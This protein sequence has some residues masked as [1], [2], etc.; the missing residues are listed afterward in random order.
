M[1]SEEMNEHTVSLVVLIAI[2]WWVQSRNAQGA[3]PKVV[4]LM[5]LMFKTL[6]AM[7]LETRKLPFAAR[8]G[9]NKKKPKDKPDAF[10]FGLW[11][12]DP[13]YVTI[14]SILALAGDLIYVLEKLM[15][16][17]KLL[18]L[19]QFMT[20]LYNQAKKFRDARDF[21]THM[22]EALR[23][24]SKHGISGPTRLECGVEF[25]ANAKNNVYLIWDENT[26]YFSFENK[27]SKVVID[28]PEFDEIFNQAR[29]LYAE[30]INN[31]T[32]QQFG[33]VMKP[34]QVYPL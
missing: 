18:E 15:T 2:S 31:P 22:D 17:P 30:I 16:L 23:D 34:D 32:S 24:H 5:P 29:K 28:K 10:T 13:D 9:A 20:P 6:D 14:R 11:L 19:G 8:S 3:N 33:K 1:G 25:T 21:F 26:L 12:K 7:Y 4:E 27:P